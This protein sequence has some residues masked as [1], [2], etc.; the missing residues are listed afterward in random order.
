[1]SM[2]IQEIVTLLNRYYPE[3]WAS[4]WDS[5]GL[6]CGRP[7]RT[8]DTVAFAVDCVP[9]TVAEAQQRGAQL[10]VTHHPL[11][12]RGVNSVAPLDYKGEMVHTLIEAGIGL[13]VAHTNAD[14][15]NPG[16]SDA[17]AQRIGLTQLRPLDPIENTSVGIGRIGAL[18]APMRLSE[19]IEHVARVLP[20][21]AWGVRATGA[22]ERIVRTVAVSGGSGDSYLG[23]AKSAGVDAFVTSD[24]RHH[25]ASEHDQE[26]GPALIDA[27]HWATE[28][29]W[30]DLVASQVA[31]TCQI[32]TVVSDVNTDPWTLHAS[33]N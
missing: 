18:P 17:L 28:R 10:L 11:Y 25:R 13:Y 21:T 4:D 27:A 33:S 6:V 2:T 3:E 16:V 14:V 29:P 22:A 30:L 32:D 1:M 26:E 12:L 20:P 15:A 23:A 31:A 24:L 9:E 8:V 19:F 5:V 7:Q